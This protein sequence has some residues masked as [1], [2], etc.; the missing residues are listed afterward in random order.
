MLPLTVEEINKKK[1]VGVLGKSL[2]DLK[3][4]VNLIKEWLKSQRHLPEEPCKLK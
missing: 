1:I 4:C 3:E 2:N